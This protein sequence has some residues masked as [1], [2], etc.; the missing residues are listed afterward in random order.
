MRVAVLVSGSGTILEALLAQ[1]IP[2]DLVVADRRCRALAIADDAG[3]P[4]ELSERD[5]YGVT[6]DRDRYSKQ[7]AATLAEHRIDLVA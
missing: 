5:S 4:N 3:V 1:G 2:V 7:V 6:F